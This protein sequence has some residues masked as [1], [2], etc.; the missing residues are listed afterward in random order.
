MCGNAP[1]AAEKRREAAVVD[2]PW[3]NLITGSGQVRGRRIMRA[4]YRCVSSDRCTPRSLC[5]SAQAFRSGPGQEDPRSPRSSTTRTT[6]RCCG[7]SKQA[8]CSQT[9]PGVRAL[10]IAGQ[11]SISTP[12]APRRSNAIVRGRPRH[13]QV[14][15]EARRM[16]FTQVPACCS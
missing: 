6:V 8:L 1:V 9:M 7:S 2:T 13:Q 4:I 5:D 12:A 10:S 3:L 14:Y 16:A 15:D 11:A